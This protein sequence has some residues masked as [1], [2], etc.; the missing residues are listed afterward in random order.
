L[1]DRTLPDHRHQ[2]SGRGSWPEHF[3][4]N[5]FQRPGHFKR[6]IFRQKDLSLADGST[7]PSMTFVIRSL[8]V[9]NHLLENVTGSVAS[10]QLDFIHASE[11]EA[12][13]RLSEQRV[14]DRL[15]LLA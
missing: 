3:V 8:K 9:G 13:A 4:S 11:E 15:K 7:V 14:G 12:E 6:A 10:V 1:F 5:V 2:G